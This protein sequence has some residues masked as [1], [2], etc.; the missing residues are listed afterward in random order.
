MGPW[1]RLAG[2]GIAQRGPHTIRLTLYWKMESRE[3]IPE[4]YHVF[5]HAVDGQT[6]ELVAQADSPPCGGRCPTSWWQRGDLW[7]DE[8]D[9]TLPEGSTYPDAPLLL[10]VGWYSIMTGERVPAF[11]A[12]GEELPNA[13][14]V[15]HTGQPCA[16]G[17]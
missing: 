4:D 11:G 9:I 12:D 10:K 17:R 13:Q 16:Q 1:A 2:Y 5:V 14:V 6:S 7:V 8:H 3:A 15:L